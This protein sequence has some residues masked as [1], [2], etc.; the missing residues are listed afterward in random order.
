MLALA[1]SYYRTDDQSAFAT[2]WPAEV[3]TLGSSCLRSLIDKREHQ[4]PWVV[5][6]IRL[7]QPVVGSY[8][9]TA[10][11]Y[12]VTYIT[13]SSSAIRLQEA[14]NS[15][16]AYSRE[17]PSNVRPF[18]SS[19]PSFPLETTSYFTFTL[20]L[21]VEEPWSLVIGLSGQEMNSCLA[22]LMEKQAH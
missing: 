11:L 20:W 6:S 4:D 12:S 13:A 5:T 18:H 15:C 14:S 1:D 17:P 8:F 9:D 3:R 2:T 10:A 7:V 16:S 22:G 21:C 19:K